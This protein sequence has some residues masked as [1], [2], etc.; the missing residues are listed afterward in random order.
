MPKQWTLTAMAATTLAF[1]GLL[2]PA[3][4][5]PPRAEIAASATRANVPASWGDSHVFQARYV[6]TPSPVP[7]LAL[8]AW[9]VTIT[10]AAEAPVTGAT[11][12][13]L[14]G[15]PEHSHGFPTVPQVKELSGGRYLIEG[16]KFH[17]PGKW[18]VILRIEAGPASDSIRFEL[19]LR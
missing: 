7:L 3:A 19:E 8:H 5:E 16:L 18:T 2:P 13:V 12:T 4:A 6:S 10:D 1:L 9:T 15:M 17:M 14:G 11:I